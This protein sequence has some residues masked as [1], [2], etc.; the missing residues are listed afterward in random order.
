MIFFIAKKDIFY[1]IPGD[2][3]KKNIALILFI[4]V[5]TSGIT[6]NIFQVPIKTI[7]NYGYSEVK[8]KGGNTIYGLFPTPPQNIKITTKK[9]KAPYILMVTSFDSTISSTPMLDIEPE[10]IRLLNGSPFDGVT[11]NLIDIYS[12]QPLPDE[13]S[14]IFKAKQLKTISKKDLWVRVNIN[15][16]YER[17]KKHPYYESGHKKEDLAKLPM[18][19][20]SAG[21]VRK[22]STAYF[23]KINGM[24]IYDEEGALSDFYKIWRLSLKFSR[25]MK[26]GIVLD[27]EPYHNKEVKYT[28]SKIASKQRR[29]V[30]EVKERLK[31][32][33]VHLADIAADEYP[34]V[35]VISLFTYLN[36]TKYDIPNYISRGILKG[37]KEN[38]ISLKLVEGGETDI[39]YINKSLDILKEKINRRL[40][41][42]HDL[43]YE[44]SDNF[45]LG[46]TIT[47]WDD[48][49]KIRGWAKEK[50]GVESPFKSL[51]DF[52]P[53][54]KEL[55]S[56][57]NYI[58]IYAPMVTDYNPFDL[59]S[60]PEFNKKLERVIKDVLKEIGIEN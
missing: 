58:W 9:T 52:K 25:V 8:E 19:G 36:N 1:E 12:G 59:N 42:Y 4:I 3:I 22:L 35:T 18:K 32:I 26:S 60:A 34:S 37:A 49:S 17:D 21:E 11:F 7:T 40:L 6:L 30:D 5:I 44:Y 57:Y 39:N 46:G 15:R 51:E 55:F 45:H 13:K 10:I 24:D 27:F 43:L 23:D 50:A 20:I 14:V 31:N 38:N 41:I 54:L 33:G 53:Y 16:I 47:V 29:S 56:N 28:V 48:P 2:K